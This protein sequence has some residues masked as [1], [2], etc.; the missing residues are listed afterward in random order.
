MNP[1]LTYR[2]YWLSCKVLWRSCCTNIVFTLFCHK[3]KFSLSSN[4]SIPSFPTKFSIFDILPDRLLMLWYQFAVKW[5]DKKKGSLRR[6]ENLRG[7]IKPVLCPWRENWEFYWTMVQTRDLTFILESHKITRVLPL[8][9]QSSSSLFFIGFQCFL[10]KNPKLQPFSI[11]FTNPKLW[12]D[13]SHRSHVE[14]IIETLYIKRLASFPRSCCHV[15]L[16]VPN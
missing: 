12:E 2:F 14:L 6:H 5:Q 16:F 7:S 8:F 11:G 3:S 9:Y 15:I 13:L 10:T 1:H 4:F